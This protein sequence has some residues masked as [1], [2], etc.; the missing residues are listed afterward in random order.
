MI[1]PGTDASGSSLPS[2]AHLDLARVR[3]RR[4]RSTIL[5]SNSAA[6]VD[7]RAQLGG[8][9]GLRDADARS[10]VRRLHEHREA[11]PVDDRLQHARARRAASRAS[12]RPRSRRC[13]RPLRREHQLHRRLVHADRR[14]EHAGADVRH[15]G[16]L[17]QPLHR[18]VLAVRTV[19]HREHDV[20]REAG[21]DR[22][23]STRRSIVISVSPPGCA[24]R[25]ASRARSRGSRS[26]PRLDHV[27]R[28]HRARR[29][30]GSAQRPSFSIRIGDRL[31]A[32]ADRGSGTP[33][34]PTRATLRARPSGRR[35]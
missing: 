28:R 34:P 14:R 8:V 35:R 11:E 4:L 32:R 15:V 30:G 2:T 1:S 13:G 19:Q 27:G 5:R 17:E 12:A 29:G 23:R 18:A 25:C 24:T 22:R 31:V 3:A 21:D 10:E 20:E 33:P 9:L 6:S 26:S 16:E 7:R